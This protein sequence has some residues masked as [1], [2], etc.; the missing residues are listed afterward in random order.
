MRPANAH[1]PPGL[2][3][4]TKGTGPMRVL[5]IQND[6]TSPIS[7]LGEH[8]KPCRCRTGHGETASRCAAAGVARR[9]STVPSSWVVRSTPITMPIIR[10]SA[11]SAICLSAFHDQGKPLLGL[12]LGGQLLARTFGARVR[13][14]DD[15]EYGYLPIDI[16]AEGQQDDADR[17]PES[18][19]STSCNGMKTP[20]P[21]RK[22]L[23]A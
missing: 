9:L 12:C 2:G 16:T 14:N 11:R 7:L 17:R 3:I 13:V 6:P 23:S 22:A 5:V 4:C 20:L 21:C 18:H 8:L 1:H 15:F 19:A 10:P